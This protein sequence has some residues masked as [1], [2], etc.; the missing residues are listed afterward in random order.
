MKLL[1][2]HPC[3]TQAKNSIVYHTSDLRERPVASLADWIT[4]FQNKCIVDLNTLVIS[5][6]A[7]FTHPRGHPVLRGECTGR[8]H[9]GSIGVVVATVLL[10]AYS[11]SLVSESLRDNGET[12]ESC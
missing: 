4:R 2:V 3:E 9:G 6:S 10:A 5:Y 1:L 7:L 12:T 8:T 11:M